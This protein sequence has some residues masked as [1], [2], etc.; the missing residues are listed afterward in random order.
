MNDTVDLWESRALPILRYVGAHETSMG[1]ISVGEIAKE[2]GI[3]VHAVAVELERLIDAG[4][5]PGQLQKMGAGGDPSP[6]FLTESRLSERGARAV[7]V[8]PR[9][10]IL[11]KTIEERAQL[12]PDPVRRRSL[13]MLAAAV[14]EI[15][16]TMLTDLMTSAAK[17]MLNLP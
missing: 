5:I 6:W 3:D 7:S 2:T 1:F 14:K 16:V 8:W 11:L 13:L 15:G 10:E 12:E 4:Y 9:A 17:K